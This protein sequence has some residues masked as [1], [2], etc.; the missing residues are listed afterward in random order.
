MNITIREQET[1]TLDEIVINTVRDEFQSKSIT[2]R[3][4]GLPRPLLLWKGAEE[5]EEA[6]VWTNE[7]VI[8]RATELLSLSSVRWA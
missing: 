5:Y 2:A 6:G 7:S 8:A 1:I 4:N 3:I